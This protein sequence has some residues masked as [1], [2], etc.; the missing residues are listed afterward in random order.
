MNPFIP[1]VVQELLS[2]P[3]SYYREHP[4]EPASGKAPLTN[5]AFILDCSGSMS[6][7]KA[8]TIEGFNAQ[9]QT[10]KQGAE[11][12][13]RTTYTDVQFSSDVDIRKL[14][15]A[16]DQMEPLTEETYVTEGST[17]LLDA[18]GSTVAA[19]LQTEDIHSPD[20][21]MLVTVFTDGEENASRIYVGTVI[22]DMVERLEAT[23][24]WTFALV[25]PQKTVHGLADLLSV[26]L[27]NVS[28]YDERFASEKTRAMARV[29][30]ANLRF[31]ASRKQ[32]MTK[33]DKLFD[34]I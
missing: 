22:K 27:E 3:V 12:A 30:K 2:R 26:R 7:G 19:L 24:R 23:G 18:L 9:V 10:V 31:M 8:A 32:G 11:G 25:G 28:G 16:L 6:S 5:V 20:T 14:A 17:A 29:E 13:G 33:V 21:A 1:Q 4:S 34:E 15:G